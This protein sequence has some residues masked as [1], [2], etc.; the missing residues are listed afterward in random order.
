[1]ISSVMEVFT[2]VLS[3]FG[4]ALATA[5]TVFF[6]PTLNDGNGGLTMIGTVAVLTLGIGVITLVLA[7]VRNIVKG[8]N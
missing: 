3:W 4:T 1:M 2:S 6:D 8:G 5:S 7:W